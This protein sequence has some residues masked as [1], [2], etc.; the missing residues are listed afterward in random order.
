MSG[1]CGALSGG[2]LLSI[3]RLKM[4]GSSKELSFPAKDARI[5]VFY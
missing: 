2:W 4:T 1:E 3:L 5:I